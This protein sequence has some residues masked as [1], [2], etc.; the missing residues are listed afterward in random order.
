[1][2]ESDQYYIEQCLNGHPDE[3]RGLVRRYQAA[4]SAYLAGKLGNRNSAEEAA[5]ETF[6]RAYFGLSDLKKRESFYSW[7]L[8]IA[9]RV[10]KEQFRNSKPFAET[11]YPAQQTCE[12]RKVDCELEKAIAELP[13]TYR[14]II[15]LRF[16]AGRSCSQIAEHLNMPIGTVT[17]QLSRAY[18]KLRHL[19]S[20]RKEVQK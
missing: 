4:L 13:D 9:N 15:F 3:F 16:Y 17:K 20:D 1:M 12:E 19:L 6:V 2:A 7:L 14:E 18:A 5:Q 11:D 8:G 10:A